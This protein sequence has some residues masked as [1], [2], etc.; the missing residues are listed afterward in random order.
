MLEEIPASGVL[1]YHPKC[2][3][4]KLLG[5]SLREELKSCHCW[6]IWQNGL[7][8]LLGLK[9][10]YLNSCRYPE[11]RYIYTLLEARVGNIDR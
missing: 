3:Y 5:C 8:K 1:A 10:L 6:Y 4:T 11:M 2:K 7:W 9:C